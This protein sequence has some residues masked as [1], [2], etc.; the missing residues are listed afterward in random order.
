MIYIV[1]VSHH[2]DK[3]LFHSLPRVA[4]QNNNKYKIIIKDNVGSE[5]LKIFCEKR[6]IKYISSKN[7]MG[8]GENNNYVVNYILKNYTINKDDYI[9]FM[10][11][12]VTI[13]CDELLSL[14]EYIERNKFSA[15]TIDLYKNSGFSLRDGFVRTYPTL[16][17]FIYSFCFKKNKTI[18]NRE[19][20][21]EVITID[22]CA[23]SF[24]GFDL[25]E[26]IKIDGFDE[27]YFMY[28]EDLDLCYR[29]KL[30]GINV[31]YIPN[32]KAIHTAH[33]DNRMLFSRAFFWHV[34][35]SIRFLYKKARF[36]NYELYSK[37]VKSILKGK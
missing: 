20:I 26:F 18:L 34:A 8:F 31:K 7:R 33:H 27:S 3:M 2:H 32:F 1:I 21:Y 15:F 23:G 19:D 22:W 12:D 11:P 5:S 14:V 13:E 29:C 36:K 30:Y 10:N 4:T 37:S 28:C 35:S 24:I 16:F 25:N 17:D 6:F 9:I